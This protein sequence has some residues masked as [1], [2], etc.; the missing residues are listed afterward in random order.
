MQMAL[1]WVHENIQAFGGDSQQVTIFGESAG[2]A[3][4]NYNL[5]LPG[6]EPYFNRAIMQV[7]SGREFTSGGTPLG[8]YKA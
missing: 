5:L 6:N 3:A 1:R 4:V 2:S 8:G 7:T